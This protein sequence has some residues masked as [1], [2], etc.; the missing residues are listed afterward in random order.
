MPVFFLLL[1]VVFWERRGFNGLC[2]KKT[3]T[4]PW[5]NYIVL[6]NGLL[7]QR[8]KEQQPITT[9]Y[10]FTAW[11][12]IL[13][14][15]PAVAHLIKISLL[16]YVAEDS[17]SCSQHPARPLREPESDQNFV[18]ISFPIRVTCPAH[19]ILLNC[20]RKS[21][22]CEDPHHEV[23]SSLLYRKQIESQESTRKCVRNL[24]GWGLRTTEVGEGQGCW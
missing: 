16:F 22:N 2:N 12:V 20:L 3:S 4:V 15:K 7:E 1:S 5:S 10:K 24:R 6:N 18:C 21:K 13:F 11:S 14:E 19:F 8:R 23:L 17:L 9:I